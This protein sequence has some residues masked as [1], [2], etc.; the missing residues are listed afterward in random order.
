MRQL[1][2]QIGRDIYWSSVTVVN[3]R[4]LW[5]VYMLNW[6]SCVIA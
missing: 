3:R 4:Y 1:A 2:V 6:M 5:C